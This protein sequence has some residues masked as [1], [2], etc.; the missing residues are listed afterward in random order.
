M[1][2][3]TLNST[4]RG[5]CTVAAV[6]VSEAGE[7]YRAIELTC[8]HCDLFEVDGSGEWSWEDALA[9]AAAHRCPEMSR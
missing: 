9:D 5:T 8:S 7:K 3:R 2:L 1:S 4:E 6:E